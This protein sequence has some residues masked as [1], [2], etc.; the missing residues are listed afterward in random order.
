MKIGRVGSRADHTALSCSE[1]NRAEYRHKCITT[2]VMETKFQNLI[3]P[4]GRAFGLLNP[5]SCISSKENET[6]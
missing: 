2:A 6:L 3:S 5:A 1:P 4:S